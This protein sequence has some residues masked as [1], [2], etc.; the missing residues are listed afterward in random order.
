MIDFAVAQLGD[1]AFW[2]FAAI[3]FLAQLLDGMLGMGFG[4]LSALAMT[5]VGYPRAVVSASINGAKMFTGAIS[6]ISH[7]FA[8]N[9]DWRLFAWLLTGGLT[10]ALAGATVLTR[11]TAEWV[12]FAVDAYL[13]VVGLYILHRAR[14][15]PEATRVS[16][17]RVAGVGTAAG[18]LEAMIG[19]WGPLA[20]G[21]LVALGTEPRHAVGTGNLAEAIIAIVVFTILV[22]H[23]GFDQLSVAIFG[24]LA[25]ALVA[26][27][28]AA[29]LTARIPKRRLM[30]GVG[31]LVVA[32]SLLRLWRDWTA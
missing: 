5:V 26:A 3:G 1:P 16:A 12:G 19:V 25:G 21:N 15:K 30:L 20:T 14:R 2:T 8:G 6:G 11:F 32:I 17:P 27:P 28:L 10:G 31:G 9:I 4:A 29:M 18:F 24:L 7:V 22:R 13:L 23:L